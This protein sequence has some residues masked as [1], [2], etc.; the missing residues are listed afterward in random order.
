M[1]PI[2]PTLGLVTRR[3][4]RRM[5]VILAAAAMALAVALGSAAPSRAQSS[6]DL[7]RFLFA[8]TALAIIVRGIDEAHR[9]EHYGGWL[10]PQSCLETIR[11]H[12]RDVDVYHRG[13]LRRAGYRDLPE[14]CVASYRTVHGR[15]SGYEARCMHSAGYGARGHAEARPGHRSERLPAQCEMTYRIGHER[16]LGYDP[17][18]LRQSGFRRLP[19]HCELATR[20]G[21]TVLDGA[22][23]LDAGYRRARH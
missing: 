6:D 20:S 19:G 1:T 23:L 3:L 5:G 2:P 15:R 18:C 8:A 4:L 16:A 13:C 22:C 12:G 9:P 7:V 17:H 11:L 21:G 14:V 10:L